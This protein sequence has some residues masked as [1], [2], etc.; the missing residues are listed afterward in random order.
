[1]M[2]LQRFTKK[3][4]TKN[5]ENPDELDQQLRENRLDQEVAQRFKPEEEKS[6]FGHDNS[7]L[8][9]LPEFCKDKFFRSIIFYDDFT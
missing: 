2:S 3:N 6:K 5:V 8:V 4:N 9:F 7:E 1:M